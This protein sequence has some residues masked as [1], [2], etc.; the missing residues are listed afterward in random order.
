MNTF[1]IQ[2]SSEYSCSLV[3]LGTF[4]GYYADK[5][6]NDLKPIIGQDIHT[7]RPNF[8]RHQNLSNTQIRKHYLML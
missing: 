3:V 8:I 5:Y 4:V 2:I 1:D 7:H 6:A